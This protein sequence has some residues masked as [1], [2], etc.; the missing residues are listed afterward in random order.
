MK[1]MVYR[2]LA[3]ILRRLGCE[4]IR[5]RGSHRVWRCGNCTATIP[6]HSD[7]DR[8]AAGTLRQ[9]VAAL[10]PCLGEGWLDQ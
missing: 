5:T 1:P 3:R 10:A 8:I 6:A 7:G 9:I 2:D 4:D